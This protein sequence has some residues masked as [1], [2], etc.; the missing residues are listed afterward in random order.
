MLRRRRYRAGLTLFGTVLALAVFGVV[1]TSGT[2]W[3]RHRFEEQR[4]RLAGEQMVMLSGAVDSYVQAEF[5]DL[6]AL[7]AGG[8]MEVS[9][10]TLR[11]AGALTAGFPDTNALGR[12][13]RVLLRAVGT[14]AFET[15][16]TQTLPAGDTRFPASALFASRGGT[17]LGLVSPE[18][19]A[20]LA[21]PTVDADV[22]PWR[23]AFPG[24]PAP[25][26]LAVLDRHDHQSVFGDQLYRVPIAGFPDAN[27]L[28]TAL[29][30]NGHDVTNAGAVA[31][32]RLTVEQ[33][34]EVGGNL[35]V[36]AE[37][38][39]GQVLTVEGDTSVS[40][41]VNA[42]SVAVAGAASSETLA[43]SGEASVGSVTSSGPVLAG[44]IG[45]DG[46]LSATAVS[47][48]GELVAGT[49]RA[50]SVVATNAAEAGRVE[51]GE[52][53]AGSVEA[54]GGATITGHVEAGSVAAMQAFS[55]GTAGFSSLTVG[56]C[57]GC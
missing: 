27:R 1:V 53:T 21:G 36:I 5:T 55:A 8:S 43:V 56:V 2:E 54:T 10:A 26:A 18:P 25:G 4:A 14:T 31:A 57:S 44:S 49:V 11:S 33:D 9:L 38:V 48:T 30:L 12:G 19:A 17:R 28:E 35:T 34:L 15:L 13:Y 51:A 46:E 7:L 47:V 39:V 37:L 22:S 50:P 52:L 3:L 16:V 23:A 45:T 42:D 32:T 29:D 24:A 20:R 41:E 6:L 40:G